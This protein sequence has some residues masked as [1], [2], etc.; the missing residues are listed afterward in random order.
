MVT[1]TR[2]RQLLPLASPGL[3]RPGVR[4]QVLGKA[5]RGALTF[6]QFVLGTQNSPQGGRDWIVNDIEIDGKSQLAMKDLS[7][8]LFASGSSGLVANK[9][10]RAHLAFADLDVIERDRE[11]AVTVTYVGPCPEGARFFGAIIGKDPPQRPT[12]LPLT[13]API[14]GRA[15]ISARLDNPLKLD[16]LEIASGDD[17]QHWDVHDIRVD[18]Q[19]Q[20]VQTG[21]VPGAVFA[22]DAHDHYVN[23]TAGKLLEIDVEYIGKDPVTIPFIGRVLG[24]VVRDDYDQP[25]PD[26]RG[27]LR[28]S[29]HDDLGTMIL[30]TCDWRA[31]DEPPETEPG[32]PLFTA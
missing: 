15:T 28:V 17:G 1:P 9:R 16:R 10:A 8:A 27:I 32:K 3:V 14:H 19:S 5:T 13:T 25:P 6:E 7:G 11:V 30:G 22:P 4:T 23:F 21:P 12:V 31:H 20:F 29:G 2:H 26:V 18:G 24:A